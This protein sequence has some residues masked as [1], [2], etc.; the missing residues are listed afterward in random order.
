LSSHIL[1]EVEV[2]CDRVAML[3]DGRIIETGDLDGLRGLSSVH[4]HAVFDGPVPDVAARPGVS[5]VVVRGST[6]ECDLSGSM[7]E[8]LQVLATARVRH[9][10]TREPSLEELFVA[11]YGAR[12]DESRAPTVR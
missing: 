1:S 6:L 11:R 12:P 5:N 4:V 9:L 3:R 10:T 7:E 2:V 8:L